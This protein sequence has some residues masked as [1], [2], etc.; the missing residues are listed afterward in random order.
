MYT[1]MMLQPNCNYIGDQL[2]STMWHPPTSTPH[3]TYIA[4]MAHRFRH[5]HVTPRLRHM[6]HGT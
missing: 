6:P 2:H 5:S 1:L 3:G 4:Y